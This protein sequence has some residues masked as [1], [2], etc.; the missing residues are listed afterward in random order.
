MSLREIPKKFI[1][2]DVVKEMGTFVFFP[3]KN[4][5][6]L[7]VNK[8]EDERI[9]RQDISNLAKTAAN[10]DL[11]KN[12]TSYLKWVIVSVLCL[13]GACVIGYLME[14]NE[15][16][17]VLSYMSFLL[18]SCLCGIEMGLVWRSWTEDRMIYMMEN[19]SDDKLVIVQSISKKLKNRLI[20]KQIADILT[21][22]FFWLLAL[23]YLQIP[24]VFLYPVKVSAAYLPPRPSTALGVAFVSLIATIA[25]IRGPVL[26]KYKCIQALRNMS[27]FNND[28]ALK[29]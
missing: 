11:T 12:T 3:D 27:L 10:E 14:T 8:A 2:M 1:Q 7:I 9:T 18:L 24:N 28:G 15:D 29:K 21:S 13:A 5:I 19:M 4:E 20:R 26:S 16:Y 23:A 22:V 25:I 6:V 17:S